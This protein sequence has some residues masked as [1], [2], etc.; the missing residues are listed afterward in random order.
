MIQVHAIAYFSHVHNRCGLKKFP[1]LIFKSVDSAFNNKH[2]KNGNKNSSESYRE[3][4]GTEETHNDINRYDNVKYFIQQRVLCFYK[5]ML[6][7]Q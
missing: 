1:K 3:Y 2:T 6:V 4:I 7:C 5:N